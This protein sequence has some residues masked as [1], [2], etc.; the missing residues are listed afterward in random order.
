MSDQIKLL[1]VEDDQY[2]LTLIRFALRTPG[3]EFEITTASDSDTALHLARA[4]KPDLILL[5]ILLPGD[6]DGIEICRQLRS[7][8]A[9]HRTGIVMITA[10][11]DLLVRQ[12]ALAAGA[13]DYWLKPINTRSLL[14]RVRAVLKM[15][16]LK[17]ATPA[18]NF[19]RP[20]SN[21]QFLTSNF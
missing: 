12:Q 19:Q 1:I 13:T 16:N 5:D 15:L 2:L 8:P 7:D 6:A 3:A 18:S 10:L 21:V 9:L 14:E 17:R 20:T 11:N 4:L